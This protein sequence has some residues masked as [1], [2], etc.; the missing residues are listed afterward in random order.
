[1]PDDSNS[2]LASPPARAWVSNHAKVSAGVV[3]GAATALIL[4]I[5]KSK[6]G[7]DLSNDAPNITMLVMAAV[8]YLV[9]DS[10]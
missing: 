6:F 2:P 1:M 5:A 7:L 3:A 10:N 9:P 8:G 4:S